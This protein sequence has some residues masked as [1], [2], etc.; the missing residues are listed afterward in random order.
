M[1]DGQAQIASI[2]GDEM[3]SLRQHQRRFFDL[4]YVWQLDSQQLGQDL[5]IGCPRHPASVF[6]QQRAV[7]D[8]GSVPPRTPPPPRAAPEQRAQRQGKHT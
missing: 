1:T 6:N 5:P 8:G 4:Q 3:V 2:D 7:I